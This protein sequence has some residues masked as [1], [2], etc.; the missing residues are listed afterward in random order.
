MAIELDLKE[1]FLK[2]CNLLINVNGILNVKF[3]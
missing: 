3:G 2:K 1:S